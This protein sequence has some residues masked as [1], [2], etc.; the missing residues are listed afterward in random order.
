MNIDLQTIGGVVVLAV[1]L[2]ALIV[3]KFSIE[4]NNIKKLISA[5]LATIIA[6]S[7]NLLGI[8]FQDSTIVV[9]IGEIFTS[10]FASKIAYDSLAK[11]IEEIRTGT[12]KKQ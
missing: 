10:I 9:L 6:V 12:R 1:S 11:P 5:G 4:D 8:G 7:F 2:T 3:K